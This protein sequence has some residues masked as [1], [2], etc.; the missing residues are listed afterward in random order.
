MVRAKTDPNSLASD[1]RSAIE[2]ADPELPLD[3]RDEHA[4]GH[5][6]PEGRRRI[7]FSHAGHLRASGADLR[8]HRYLRP[9]CLFSRSDE[10]T[11]SESA[12]PW[13][14]DST[15]VLRMVLFEGL[16]MT[17]IGAAVGLALALPLPKV[18]N[19][20]VYRPRFR[21]AEVILHRSASD[22]R[23]L[24]AGDI[25]SRAPRS[26]RRSDHRSAQQLTTPMR[27][28]ASRLDKAYLANDVGGLV[29]PD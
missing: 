22:H 27:A 3:A 15:Q 21:R 19:C 10:P 7:V 6:P 9:D 8:S 14:Q 11:R 16:K 13:E 24:H 17:A 5:R 1:L 23:G 26:Q 20:H 4:R 28:R 12:W 18:F 29:R 2:Q 25:H